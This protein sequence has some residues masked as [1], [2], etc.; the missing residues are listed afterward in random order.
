MQSMLL[1]ISSTMNFKT[2]YIY[3]LYCKFPNT[4]YERIRTNSN[5]F[6]TWKSS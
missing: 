3:Y 4:V 5:L 2:Y 1:K 6:P